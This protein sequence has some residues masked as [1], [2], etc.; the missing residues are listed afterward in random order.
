[1]KMP[2]GSSRFIVMDRVEVLAIKKRSKAAD[3][4]PWV[5]DESEMWKKTITRRA[6]KPFAGVSPEIDAALEADADADSITITTD[7]IQMPKAL[8]TAAAKTL[9]ENTA[10]GD[11]QPSEPEPA[12]GE[13]APAQP[14]NEQPALT[15]RQ[16]LAQALQDAGVTLEDAAD[17][18]ETNRLIPDAAAVKSI[19]DLPEETCT[20][21]ATDTKLMAKL[22]K[23]FGAKAS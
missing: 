10:K 18:M 2:D 7:P 9:P 8:P 14:A 13:G 20:R 6:M 19:N 17:F 1:M 4:G 12:T 22:I 3:Y 21:L 15:M 5:S 23:T 16:K 11:G